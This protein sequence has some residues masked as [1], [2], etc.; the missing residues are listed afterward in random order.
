MNPKLRQSA[1]GRECTLRLAGAC[2]RNPETTVLCHVKTG[3]MGRKCPDTAAF[4][5]CSDCHSI[6]DRADS[7]WMDYGQDY[8]AAQALRALVETH[9][10][11][12]TEGLLNA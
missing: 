8:L 5:G 10:I 6:Y 3:G 1:R 2:N 9:E 12:K 7:R 4:F 11:W